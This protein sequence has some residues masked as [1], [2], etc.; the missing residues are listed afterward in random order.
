MGRL[1]V[2]LATGPEHP[3]RA[4]LAF[5]VA[6]MAL[7]QGHDVNLFLAGDAL[8]L[9]REPTRNAVIGVGT[10]PLAEHYAEIIRLG[11]RIYASRLSAE[12][13]AVT[14]DL[15]PEVEFVEPDRL[16]EFIFAAE[17]TVAY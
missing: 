16:I 7:E 2:H 3:T 15:A 17:R 11:G 6:R 13:R 10:G 14:A 9:L 1:L 5:R 4:A 12:A 8:S